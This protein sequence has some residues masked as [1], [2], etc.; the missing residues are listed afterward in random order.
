MS[1]GGLVGSAGQPQNVGNQTSGANA[2]QVL[3]PVA[4]SPPTA[5]RL[6]VKTITVLASA[7][8]NAVVTIQEGGVT[9]MNF[10]TLVLGVV[11]VVLKPDYRSNTLL[12]AQVG[13]SVGAAGAAVTTTVSAACDLVDP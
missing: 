4:I 6:L 1:Q 11:A 10:G 9:V 3:V 12:P 8:G 2:A 7:V 5:K 13:I